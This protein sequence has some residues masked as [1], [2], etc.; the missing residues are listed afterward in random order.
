MALRLFYNCMHPGSRIECVF[1]KLTR[2]A[3]LRD[4]LIRLLSLSLSLS[5]SVSLSLSISPFF[6]CSADIALIG[7]AV[8]VSK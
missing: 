2:L 8:M 3:F 1:V 6:T 7:L 4:A 5:L